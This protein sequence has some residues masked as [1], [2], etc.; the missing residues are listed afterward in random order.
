[1]Y[2]NGRYETYIDKIELAKSHVYKI[3]TKEKETKDNDGRM[4][5]EIENETI[6]KDAPKFVIDIDEKLPKQTTQEEIIKQINNFL[7][8]KGSQS[9]IL[10]Y[11]RQFIQ[12][13][14]QFKPFTEPK[15]EQKTT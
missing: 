9:Q 2:N 7:N 10:V 6:E 11:K 4:I 15:N 12:T 5:R 13:E 14:P 3:I 1:L 8:N